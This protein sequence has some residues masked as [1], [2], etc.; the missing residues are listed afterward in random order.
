LQCFARLDL[1]AV[2]H[3]L[4]NEL[5][6]DDIGIANG[7]VIRQCVCSEVKIPKPPGEIPEFFDTVAQTH[8]AVFAP[9]H[10]S[11][12]QGLEKN[13]YRYRLPNTAVLLPVYHHSI[14]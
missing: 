5:Q 10:S 11:S 6:N 12:F 2:L 1:L 13:N 4:K 7:K 3:V 14:F 8:C 9:L